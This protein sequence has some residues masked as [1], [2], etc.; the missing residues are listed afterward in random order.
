MKLFSISYKVSDLIDIFCGCIIYKLD[1]EIL[2]KYQ[3][4]GE[5]TLSLVQSYLQVG[6]E[7]GLYE[8]V[9]VE[10]GLYERRLGMIELSVFVFLYGSDSRLSVL[11]II[12]NCM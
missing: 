7:I 2:Q 3:K 5:Y 4:Y 11:I 1:L 12:I 10:I 9:G 6:V 8:Q